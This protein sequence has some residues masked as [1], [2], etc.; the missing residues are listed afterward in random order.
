MK[1]ILYIICLGL[2]IST[3]WTSCTDDLNQYPS[4]EETSESVYTSAANYKM[5]LA[6]LYASFVLA[7]QEQGGGDADIT[8]SNTGYDYMRVYINMQEVPTDEVVYTWAEGDKLYDLTYLS[9][10]END[11][12]VSDMYYH[13]YYTIALCNEFIRN[14]TDDKISGFSASDQKEIRAYRA[15]ARFIRALAYYHALDLYGNVPYVDENDPVGDYMPPQYS[16]TEIFE[17]IESE[18]KDISGELTLPA[19]TEYDRASRAAAW[20]LLAKLYLNGEV[21]TGT[22]YNDQCINYCDS[23]IN[24]NYFSL[25]S[26]Y[27]HLFNADNNLR[28][29]EI[30]F[31]FGIDATYSVSWGSTT[32]LVCGCVSGS[33]ENQVAA[34]YGVASGWGSIRAKGAFTSLFSDLTGATD[35]RA[36][37]F[38]TGQTQ[39]V[40]DITNQLTGYLYTKWTN[41]TDDGETASNTSS[42]GVNTD[43]PVFRLADVYLMYAEAILRG[44]TTGS[45]ANALK[46]VNL[47]RE[48]AYGGTSGDISSS[49]LTLDFILNERGRE[50][51]LECT[52]RTDLIRYDLFTSSDYVWEFKGGSQAGTGV[53]SK[54]NLYPIPATE[55]SANSNIKQNENY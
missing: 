28:T 24:L 40:T 47:V 53:D 18:L 12:W 32:Y 2:I 21:Y 46:Y 29:N 13:I 5:V 36:K 43:Y 20:T 49:D 44:G 10:D 42:S 34:D 16:R 48:R 35:T 51:Y 38:T 30:I 14:A 41:L 4:I 23:I 31:T 8:D 54:Y 39:S 27:T 37:F 3:T 1:K 50:L 6:K 22:S 45:S 55:L 17:F 19:A 33:N 52:R 7:G 26:N 25:E 11:N 9:W 15:E